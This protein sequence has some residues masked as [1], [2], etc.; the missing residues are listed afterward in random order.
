VKPDLMLFS[1]WRRHGALFPDLVCWHDSELSGLSITVAGRR[2][3]DR[4]QELVSL[5]TRDVAELLRSFSWIMSIN[6][7]IEE[8]EAGTECKFHSPLSRR[9]NNKEQSELQNWHRLW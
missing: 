9:E 7:R 6:T 5:Q 2:L 4:P 8:K 1:F 3:V